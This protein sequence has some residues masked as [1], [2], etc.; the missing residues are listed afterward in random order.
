MMAGGN[1]RFTSRLSITIDLEKKWVSRI[2]ILKNIECL[3]VSAVLSGR[4]NS[5]GASPMP[6]SRAIEIKWRLR[7]T[8]SLSPSKVRL[9]C[10][11]LAGTV[12]EQSG[13]VGRVE[14]LLHV[15]AEHP[16]GSLRKSS[17]PR[18]GS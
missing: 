17:G 9:S 6:L 14:W 8:T 18:A 13:V 1:G 4:E 15:V 12:H 7:V 3:F 10:S 16:R 2:M 5:D 11:G